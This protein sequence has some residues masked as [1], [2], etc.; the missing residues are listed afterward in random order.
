MD[1]F[2][3]FELVTD[4]FEKTAAFYRGSFWLEN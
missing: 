1:R 2:T 4:D 3:H